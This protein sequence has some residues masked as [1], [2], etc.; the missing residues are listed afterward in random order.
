MPGLKL[1][2][3]GILVGLGYLLSPLSWWN[4][5]FFNFPIAWAF[6]YGVNWLHSGWFVPATVGGYWLSNVAGM[7][8]MQWGATDWLRPDQPVSPWRALAMGLGTSTLYT[9]VVAALVYYHLLAL[10]TGLLP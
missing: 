6:G 3:N 7:V 4:D 9:A 5:F 10:P 2:K 1:F 8:M